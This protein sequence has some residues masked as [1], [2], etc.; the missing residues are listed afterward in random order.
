MLERIKLDKMKENLL[1][2][3]TEQISKGE[4][5]RQRLSKLSGLIELDEL[6]KDYDE[7]DDFNGDFLSKVLVTPQYKDIYISV[8][9]LGNSNISPDS[10]QGK[11]DR[12]YDE[13]PKKID[14]LVF[15]KN[16]INDSDNKFLLP[17]DETELTIGLKSTQIKKM[18][19]LFISHA[20]LDAKFL[21]PM[22]DLIEYIGVPEKQIFFSSHPTFGVKLGEDIIDWLKREL[23][24]EVFALF[25]LTENFYKSPV[26]LCEMGAVWIKSHKQVAILIPPFD[27]KEMKGVISNSLGFKYND[28]KQLNRFKSE[29]ESF[30]D[31]SSKDQ[32]RWE[33]KRDEYLLKVN[34]LFPKEA[35]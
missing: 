11:R 10:F 8:K 20:S 29:L 30:F 13:L 7:W 31:L 2:I 35:S 28:Q 25:M 5:L 22:I 14:R 24:G 6:I 17:F 18:K 3:I 32:T 26:C 19:K 12:L 23:N 15:A 4:G 33:E 27:F 34:S 9:H 1:K 16:F 21:M